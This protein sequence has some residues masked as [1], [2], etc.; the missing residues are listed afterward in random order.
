[1]S[2]PMLLSWYLNLIE[3]SEYIEHTHKLNRKQIIGLEER[4]MYAAKHG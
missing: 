2:S 4:E 1:M 3:F